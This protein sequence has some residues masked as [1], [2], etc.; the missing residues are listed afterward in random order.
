MK[1]ETVSEASC[2]A[3]VDSQ[4]VYDIRHHFKDMGVLNVKINH[5]ALKK[6][7][8]ENVTKKAGFRNIDKIL[9]VC[10][11]LPKSNSQSRFIESLK[12]FGYVVHE[13][14]HWRTCVPF[15]GL[16]SVSDL[17][18]K[19]SVPVLFPIINYMI[20]MLSSR[21]DS[22]V[23]VVSGSFGLYNALA[24]FTE[25]RGGKAV[26]AFFQRFLDPRWNIVGFNE[27]LQFYDLEQ[28]SEELLGINI[29]KAIKKPAIGI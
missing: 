10:S 7:L 21:A 17:T 15:F 1:G 2:L 25:N 5:E 24:D 19:N 9:V 8:E 13:V 12:S 14:A 27:K 28:H 23:V 6:V 29:S 20:G 18:R 22:Q 4:D 26:L 11:M 16:T 3:I